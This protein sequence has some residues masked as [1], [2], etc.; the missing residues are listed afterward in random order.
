M[1]NII[2]SQPIFNVGIIGAVSDGKTTLVKKL[3]G[4]E[5]QRHSH[6]KERNITIKQGYGNMKIWSKNSEYITTHGD[7]NILDEIPDVTLVNHI[8]FVDCP[9][10]QDYIKTMLT[11]TSLMYAV[12]IVIAVDQ[13]LLKKNT[14]IQH[15]LATKTNN[16]DTKIIICLNKIDLVKKNIVLAR[17][18]ELELLCSELDIKPYI[19]IPCCFNKNIGLK[20]I[21]TSLQELLNPEEYYKKLCYEEP[22]FRINRSFDINKPGTNIDMLNGGIIGGTL[23]QGCLKVQD[24][25]IILP[26]VLDS[27]NN[28]IPIKTTIKSIKTEKKSID[29]IY[30]GG[31]FGICT[32]I[33]PYYTK[34]D[35]LKGTIATNKLYD[36][37]KNIL[38]KIIFKNPYYTKLLETNVKIEIHQ[39]ITIIPGTVTDIINDVLTI[40]LDNNINIL[41]SNNVISILS[42]DKPIVLIAICT[43]V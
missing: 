17:K 34:N 43:I 20:Y 9:G 38:I 39:G 2:E 31:L 8:S 18:K 11:S 10:H 13:S 21:I 1:H 4:I 15:M 12:I 22:I 36:N 19:I 37:Y 26:G 23:I 28:I 6:E 42:L 35:A 40:E 14:L 30:P 29:I 25:I 3:T 32:D 24:E 27:Q 7:I 16:L 41:L 33:D 5:T